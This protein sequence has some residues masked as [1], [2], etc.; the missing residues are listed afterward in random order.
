[1]RMLLV[2][3]ALSP[4]LLASSYSLA[5]AN[6]TR[7]HK[8]VYQLTANWTARYDKAKSVPSDAAVSNSEHLGL[9][10][11]VTPGPAR[12]AGDTQLTN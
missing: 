2:L 8:G 9:I 6:K 1:M 3:A 7:V 11:G 4:L 5:H 12:W 10:N